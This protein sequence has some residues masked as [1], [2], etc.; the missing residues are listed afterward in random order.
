[1]K[2]NKDNQGFIVT[3]RHTKIVQIYNL[4]EI[5]F[6]GFSSSKNI[7]EMGFVSLLFFSNL[8]KLHI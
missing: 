8:Y 5:F 6:S 2:Q 7:T 3:L 1:M 4:W